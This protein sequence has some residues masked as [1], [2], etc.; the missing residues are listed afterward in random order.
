MIYY[1]VVFDAH[2]VFCANGLP[3]ESYLPSRAALP[4]LD[5]TVR[6]DLA[7]LF[8]VEESDGPAFPAP[9]YAAPPSKDYRP[10]LV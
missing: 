2:Q 1:N 3:V 6:C 4:Q 9:R 7:A 8:A 5:E 10:E